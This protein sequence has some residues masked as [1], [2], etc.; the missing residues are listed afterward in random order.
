MRHTHSRYAKLH[1]DFGER[2]CYSTDTA[3]I[4]GQAMT[5]LQVE[6][7]TIEVYANYIHASA[8]DYEG[9]AFRTTSAARHW[10]AMD[11]EITESR[12]KRKGEGA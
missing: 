7:G 3:N 2:V 11:Y 10:L 9:A 1:V 8:N 4:E 12:A 6:G 5:R